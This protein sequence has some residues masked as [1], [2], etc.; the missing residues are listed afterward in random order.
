MKGKTTVELTDVITGEVNAYED[1]NL[2]TDAAAKI[3]SAPGVFGSMIGD[4]YFHYAPIYQ[5][6]FGGLYLFDDVLAESELMLPNNCNAVG[7]AAY[8]YVESLGMQPFGNYNTAE[9]EVTDTY[10][11]MVFDFP[12]D[13]A[14]GTI[15]SI[16][17]GHVQGAK[18]GLGGISGVPSPAKYYS[19]YPY[20]IYD[21]LQGYKTFAITKQG[22][23][24][25]SGGFFVKFNETTGIYTVVKTDATGIHIYE[26]DFKLRN[27]GIKDRAATIVKQKDI[28]AG[29][30]YQIIG[31]DRITKK[32]YAISASS[33]AYNA[34]GTL[35]TVDLS[36]ADILNATYATRTFTNKSGKT[37]YNDNQFRPSCVYNG[38]MYSFGNG[39]GIQRFNC[40]DD[41]DAEFILPQTG[42]GVYNNGT[43]YYY[44]AGAS[45]INGLIYST[46]GSFKVYN[47][48]TRRLR[49]YLANSNTQSVPTYSSRPN[50]EGGL[51]GM[52]C[53]VNVYNNLFAGIYFG[54]LATINNLQTPVVKTADKTMKITY[55]LDL[56]S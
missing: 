44:G 6:L 27:L 3:L 34:T 2:I 12:T 37:F 5:T 47:P 29:I 20:W 52:C 1:N 30:N 36:D 9:S 22:D 55:T 28:P 14:N 51:V 38:N 32:L 11:K 26:Y 8:N 40:D 19:G 21:Q 15:A 17:L 25:G 48:I 23:I 39:E 46:G 42:D 53:N 16:C 4:P 41:N 31:Y 45:E 35:V 13:R 43:G 56:T 54:A 7:Y 33:I 24:F 18:M 49:P 10:V 50:I